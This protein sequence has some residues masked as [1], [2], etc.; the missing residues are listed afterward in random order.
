MLE[1]S[2]KSSPAHNNL[3]MLKHYHF[4]PYSQPMIGYSRRT[5]WTQTMTRSICASCSVSG[6]QKCP[7][8]RYMKASRRC[9]QNSDSRSKFIQAK[10]EISRLRQTSALM[11]V[12]EIIQ[13]CNRMR[14][15]RPAMNEGAHL[16]IH[17]MMQTP[18]I[19]NPKPRALHR[20]RPH[21]N[22]LLAKMRAKGIDRKGPARGRQEGTLDDQRAPNLSPQKQGGVG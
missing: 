12:S 17:Y 7:A 10:M 16:S 9:W 8:N 3:Q 4:A 21:C 11:K 1:Y 13:L 19:S 18:R 20:E 2:T 6:I 14:M 22:I 15:A 5:A